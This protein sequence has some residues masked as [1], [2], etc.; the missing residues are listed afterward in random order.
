MFRL[1][2]LSSLNFRINNN[3]SNNNKN[4]RN[5]NN[6]NDRNT[7]SNN[8]RNTTSNNNN[9]NIT[10]N[11][12]INNDTCNHHYCAVL[13]EADR[14]LDEGFKTELNHIIEH[15]PSHKQ[16]LLYSAT[17]TKCLTSLNLKCSYVCKCF[18]LFK[19]C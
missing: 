19:L 4:N 9:R 12:H 6:N 7:T 3:T 5:T 18:E 1:G 10:N 13:D 8:D 2:Q 14:M 16:T 15:L 17:Q 11:N